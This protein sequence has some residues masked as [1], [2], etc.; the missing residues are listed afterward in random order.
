[1]AG[2]PVIG[3]T[4]LVYRLVHRVVQCERFQWL[5]CAQCCFGN[6][7]IVRDV[8]KQS[9]KECASMFSLRIYWSS[10]STFWLISYVV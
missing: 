7:G 10:R 3:W 5:S 2:Y 6:V 1:M 4:V 8:G 9:L